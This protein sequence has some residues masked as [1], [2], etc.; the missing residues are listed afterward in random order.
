MWCGIKY[1]IEIKN[2]IFFI[3]NVEV[4]CLLDTIKKS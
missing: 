4:L 1:K 3:K 2:F